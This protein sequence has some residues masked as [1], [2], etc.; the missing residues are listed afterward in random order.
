MNPPGYKILYL[1]GCEKLE[2]IPITYYILEEARKDV[3][4]LKPDHAK[5]IVNVNNKDIVWKSRKFVDYEY[6]KA[7]VDFIH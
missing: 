2:E 3:L 5:I 6:T 7:S 1:D 4:L